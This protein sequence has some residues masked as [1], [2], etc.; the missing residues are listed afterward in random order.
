MGNETVKRPL[1]VG[2][3]GGIGSGKSTVSDLFAEMGVPVIDA[4]C[5]AHEVVQKGKPAYAAI[6]GLFGNG[7]V[8]ENGDLNRNYLRQL[9]FEDKEKRRQLESIIHP[10]VRNEID[11]RSGKAGYP[12]CII[13]IP[14][15]FESGRQNSV[16]RIL[17][18]DAPESLQLERASAR[19]GARREDIMKII[20]AQTD[21][22]QRVEQ[23]DDIITND[24]DLAKLRKQVTTLHNKYLAMTANSLQ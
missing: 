3:T 12:Y 18:I 4:D 17:V 7:I 8:D 10:L 22:R 9:I 16:D 23:A 2:L 15:L 20:D 24:R 19:D 14:L 21:R 11:L 5:I 1:R 13:S 6:I